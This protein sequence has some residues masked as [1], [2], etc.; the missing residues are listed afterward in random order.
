V[1]WVSVGSINVLLGSDLE[2]TTDPRSGWK[3]IVADHS[4]A[5]TPRAHVL[6][7]PHHGSVT[8]DHPGVWATMLHADATTAL[9]P[10]RRCHLPQPGDLQR[11]KARTT[12]LYV[13][14]DPIGRKPPRRDPAVERTM[15]EVAKQRRVLHGPMG[16]VR[17]RVPAFGGA[18]AVALFD[19][20][21]SP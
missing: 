2:D 19:G 17:L 14:A 9:T 4:A 10:F 20:A 6:K 16:H 3:G 15:R 5:Q 11:L 8:A 21:Y 1:I 12:P 13:T 18:V 7:V